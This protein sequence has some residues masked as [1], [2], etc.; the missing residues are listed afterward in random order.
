MWGR[1]MTPSVDTVA[2]HVSASTSHAAAHHK[3]N[4]NALPMPKLEREDNCGWNAGPKEI[5]FKELGEALIGRE[6]ARDAFLDGL[7]RKRQLKEQTQ[8]I[9]DRLERVGIAGRTYGRE[10]AIVGLVSGQAEAVEPFRNCNML[11]AAQSRN[12]HDMLKSVRYLFDVTKP[13]RLRMLVVS[14]GWVPLE[15]YRLHHRAHTRRMSKFAAHPVLKELGIDVEFYNV[16]NTIQRD[17]DGAAML[18]LHSHV[19]FKCRRK[20]GA[21]RWREFL[22]FARAYFPKG[23][24]HDSQVQKPAEVVKYVFKPQEFEL[25]TDEELGELFL[26]TAGGRPKI[27]PET[28]EVEMRIGPEGERI[29]VRERGLKFFHPLGSLRA[30]RRKLR[31]NGQKLVMVPTVDDRLIWRVTEPKEA[32]A[33]PDPVDDRPQHNRV[34]AITRPMPKFSQRMEPCLVVMNYDGDFEDLIRRNNL[35]ETIAEVRAL[36]RAREAADRRAGGASPMG[37]TTTTTVREREP[38]PDP[39]PPPDPPGM[40]TETALELTSTFDAPG[41]SPGGT[42]TCPGMSPG[43]GPGKPPGTFPRPLAKE[44]GAYRG[45]TPLRTY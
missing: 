33:R 2:C 12:V 40:R 29:E 4:P 19:L 5:T 25:L 10:T 30:F 44:R 27:D 35:H 28:G 16:E 7:S 9:I 24:V 41:N 3:G 11:P 17:D 21:K 39:K 31:E 20:L 42:E 34:L 36:F 37:H 18:N 13:G 23:Y 26:Q 8:D 6:V 32:E 43:Y 38:P 22:E 14:G 1:L 15:R 45:T